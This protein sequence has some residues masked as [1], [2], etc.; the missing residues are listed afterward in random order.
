VVILSATA[1]LVRRALFLASMR[2]MK[3]LAST[4]I[5]TD[6]IAIIS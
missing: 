2:A 5:A 4:I 1:A 6:T 3:A